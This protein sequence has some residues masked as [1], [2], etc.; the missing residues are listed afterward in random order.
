MFL[1]CTKS[2]STTRRKRIRRP[3]S[4]RA[5]VLSRH[6]GT[7]GAGFP[8]ER[9]DQLDFDL[10]GPAVGDAQLAIGFAAAIVEIVVLELDQVHR[11]EQ[12][13]IELERRVHVAHDEAE[14]RGRR[15][16]KVLRNGDMEIPSGRKCA[17][18]PGK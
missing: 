17:C 16:A 1:W 11:T 18:R 9:L 12:R 14:L 7:R 5:C 8:R 4:T 6:R 13:R 10:A 3:G 15:Q 2:T